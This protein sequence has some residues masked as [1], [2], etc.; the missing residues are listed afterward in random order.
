MKLSFR[1]A[2]LSLYFIL[3]SVICFENGAWADSSTIR[4][5]QV[6]EQVTCEALNPAFCRGSSGFVVRSGGLYLVGP[7][8]SGRMLYG[9]VTFQEW[10]R[11][12][13]EGNN[14]ANSPASVSCRPTA[15]L[16]GLSD[17]IDLSS[18]S[19]TVRVYSRNGTRAQTC[20]RGRVQAVEALHRDVNS[21]M[22]KYTPSYFP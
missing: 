7:S 17:V 6:R 21:L 10:F 20:Y 18:A 12:L 11:L 15:R 13:V 19:K 8:P 4:W 22:R 5:R 1:K 2:T 3:F 16:P 14:V 9:F